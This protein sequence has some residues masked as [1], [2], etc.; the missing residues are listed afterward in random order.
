M[1]KIIEVTWVANRRGL[2]IL[3]EYIKGISL[4]DYLYKKDFLQ[5]NEAIEITISLCETLEKLHKLG[6]IHADI[7]PS[8]I[9]LF[10]NTM[11]PIL[12]D[13]G[14]AK[15]IGERIEENISFSLPYAPPE[16]FWTD[17]LFDVK[18]DIY[19]LG[20]TLL[21]LLVGFKLKKNKSF[22]NS[23]TMM[24]RKDEF[25][26]SKLLSTKEKEKKFLEIQNS[27]LRIILRKALDSPENR[28]STISDLLDD[29]Y[30]YILY[31]KK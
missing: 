22:Y 20:V 1:V 11:K 31:H 23:E 5:Q 3:Q 4:E 24:I 13:F 10:E 6:I 19:S 29:L 2:I 18:F 7:K 25:D 14:N 21:E 17:T 26:F 28:Y 12:I 27:Q 30:H 15:Y 16:I 8:N 9:L